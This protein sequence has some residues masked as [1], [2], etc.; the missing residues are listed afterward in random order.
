MTRTKKQL[1]V[2]GGLLMTITPL[3]L[4]LHLLFQCIPELSLKFKTPILVVCRGHPSHFAKAYLKMSFTFRFHPPS[5]PCSYSYPFF[6]LLPTY[7]VIDI[8]FYV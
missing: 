5:P 6:C 7:L 2:W 4:L 1:R 8:Y 3:L